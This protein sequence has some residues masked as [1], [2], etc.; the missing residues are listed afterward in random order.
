MQI[1]ELGQDLCE[2]EIKKYHNPYKLEIFSSESHQHLFLFS[3]D[4]PVRTLNFLK[5]WQ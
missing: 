1:F 2:N 3:H 5:S 4:L